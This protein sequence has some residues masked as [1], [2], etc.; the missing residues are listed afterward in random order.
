MGDFPEGGI[1]VGKDLH[2]HVGPVIK[3][4]AFELPVANAEPE[5]LDKVE[6][7]MS[8]GACPCNIARVGG[9]FRLIKKNGTGAVGRKPDFGSRMMYYKDRMTNCRGRTAN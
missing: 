4:G 5:R 6:R 3:S 9:Y 8:G 7:R 2:M 1:E